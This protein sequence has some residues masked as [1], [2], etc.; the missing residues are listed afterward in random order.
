MLIKEECRLPEKMTNAVLITTRSRGSLPLIETI[1]VT[2]NGNIL[3]FC[4][5][6]WLN[7]TAYQPI[8]ELLCEINGFCH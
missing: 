6:C 8:S 1:P 3:Y 4:H 7:P 5:D 2:I